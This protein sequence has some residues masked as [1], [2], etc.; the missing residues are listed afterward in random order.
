M[1]CGNIIIIRKFS[2]RNSTIEPP[3]Q[4]Q[5][6]INQDMGWDNIPDKKNHILGNKD[7]RFSTLDCAC[8]WNGYVLYFCD[9]MV[10]SGI[11]SWSLFSAVFPVGLRFVR[12]T[13][14]L[15]GVMSH[16]LDDSKPGLWVKEFNYVISVPCRV[17]IC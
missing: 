16:A 17:K 12:S 15:W 8:N 2:L 10:S 14:I 5:L 4:K 3:K 1:P 6:K 7:G 13:L 11:K 9:G